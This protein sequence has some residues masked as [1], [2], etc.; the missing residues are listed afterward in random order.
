MNEKEK[1]KL[2]N[3]ITNSSYVNLYFPN[4]DDGNAERARNTAE[5]IIKERQKKDYYVNVDIKELPKSKS[6]AVN[7]F[8]RIV[9][10]DL[11]K[12][13]FEHWI[14]D[15]ISIDHVL[16]QVNDNLERRA[17]II[18]HYFE[19]QDN[20]QEKGILRAIRKF[21]E[22]RDSKLLGILLISSNG[23]DQWD[24]SPF[25]NLDERYIEP[26]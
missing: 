6:G 21:I 23:I 19:N 16:K 11:A 8:I 14:H 7:E 10:N 25:S 20:E 3:R 26:L 12:A 9:N 5:D 24:L 1:R 13:Q 15:A 18:F 17:L 4:L 2:L 22:M